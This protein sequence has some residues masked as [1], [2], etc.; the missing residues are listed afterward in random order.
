[1]IQKYIISGAPGTGKTTIINAL[2]K[3]DHYCAEEI[4]RELITEQISIGGNILPWKDQIAFE[5]QIANRRY[6][7]YLDSPENCICFFDRSSVDCIA[8]LNNNKLESTSQINQ[9][10]KNCIFN[11]TV[12]YTP[13]WEEI[14]KNDSE[15][16]E[17]FDQ[18]IKI[19]KHLKDSYLKFGYTIIEIPKTTLDKRVNF[20]LSQIKD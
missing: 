18:S 19:D 10:I 11:K 9:I 8:Y 12:F 1:M 15:R 17:S 20:I 13:I 5:N 3:K 14:Y 7:Q 6:K 16:Q 4:S 2:K